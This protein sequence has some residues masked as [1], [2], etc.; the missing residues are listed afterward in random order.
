MI[1]APHLTRCSRPPGPIPGPF[2]NGSVGYA[3]RS[4]DRTEV[5]WNVVLV[6]DTLYLGLAPGGFAA[7]TLETLLGSIARNVGFKYVT[8]RHRATLLTGFTPVSI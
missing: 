8:P 3:T 7:G 2:A 5:V 6:W 1:Y 4:I